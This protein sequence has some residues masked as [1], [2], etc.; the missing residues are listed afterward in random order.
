MGSQKSSLG[1]PD[2]IAGVYRDDFGSRA[3]SARRAAI[4]RRRR[5]RP[6]RVRI[7]L[8][9]HS[10]HDSELEF[11]LKSGEHATCYQSVSLTGSTSPPGPDFSSADL[12]LPPGVVVGSRGGKLVCGTGSP[13][14][15]EGVV[16]TPTPGP[17]G[18]AGK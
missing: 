15:V 18:I 3:S 11:E 4:A 6:R 2:G 7:L 8:W 12:L 1:R 17:G 13:L 10:N 14:V 9:S 16:G 5:R